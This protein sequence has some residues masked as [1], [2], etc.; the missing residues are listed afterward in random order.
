MIQIENV[1]H[2]SLA[3]TISSNMKRKKF[4]LRAF[5]RTAISKNCFKTRKFITLRKI[6]LQVYVIEGSQIIAL[7][8]LGYCSTSCWTTESPWTQSCDTLYPQFPW[9]V[10]GWHGIVYVLPCHNFT[11]PTIVPF[12]A[13]HYHTASRTSLRILHGTHEICASILKIF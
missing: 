12:T 10:R 5:N 8:W 6:F 2:V 7:Q 13:I 1:P 11:I 9:W 4:T 3:W